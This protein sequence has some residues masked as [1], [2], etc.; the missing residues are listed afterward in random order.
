LPTSLSANFIINW[1]SKIPR[2]VNSENRKGIKCVRN[3]YRCRIIGLKI[4]K[5]FLFNK[6]IN[7]QL[8]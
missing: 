2:I 3:M 8:E 4:A 6:N 1:R 5:A 7:G